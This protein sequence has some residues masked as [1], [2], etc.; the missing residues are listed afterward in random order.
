MVA[1]EDPGGRG[2]S[3]ALAASTSDGRYMDART[4]TR[5]L[6]NERLGAAGEANQWTGRPG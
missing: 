3:E 6:A 5:G 4:L 1:D 2:W